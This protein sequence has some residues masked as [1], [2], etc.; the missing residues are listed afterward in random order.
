MAVSERAARRKGVDSAVAGAA[1]IV[2]CPHLEA[3]HLL[4]KQLSGQARARTAH[5]ILGA[6]VPII[7][8]SKDDE[9]L[10]RL[11]SFAL[12]SMLSADHA[13]VSEEAE[14]ID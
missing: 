3:G 2:V 5:V 7:L 9:T 1:D 12:V 14:G 8:P 6:R 13:K 11:A 10:P 4:L